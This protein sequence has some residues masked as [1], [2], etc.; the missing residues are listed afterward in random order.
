MPL[1]D[2]LSPANSRMRRYRERQD[3]GAVVVSLEIDSDRLDT[4]IDHGFL[5]EGDIKSRTKISEAVDLILS[6]LADGAA[7]MDWSKYD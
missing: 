7:E 5:D 1:E 4:L 3:R 6:A 2:N